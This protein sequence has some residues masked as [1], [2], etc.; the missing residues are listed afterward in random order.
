MR[1]VRGVFGNRE[2]RR[3]ELAFAA[4]NERFAAGQATIAL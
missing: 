2:L 4:F 1:V 3:V